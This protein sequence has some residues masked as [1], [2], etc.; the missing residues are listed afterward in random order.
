M[1]PE[2]PEPRPVQSGAGSPDIL[3]WYRSADEPRLPARRARWR[4]ARRERLDA[5]ACLGLSALCFSHAC[6]EI[7]FRADRDFYNRVPVRA[8]TLLALVLNIVAVGALGFAGVQ[9]IR[10]AHRLVWRRLGAIAISAGLLVTLNFVRITYAPLAQ[11]ADWLRT[12]GLLAIVVMALGAALAWPGPALYVM[13]RVALVASPVT[14]VILWVVPWMFL[15]AAVGPVWRPTEPKPL[16]RTPPS[17]RR[18][19]WIVFGELDQRITFEARPAGLDLP[20]LDRLRREAL[21]AV[22]ARPPAAATEVTMPALITGRPVV[23]VAPL[24]PNDLELT[25]TDGKTAPWSAH[26]NVFTRTRTQGYDTALIGWGLPYPRVLGGSLGAADWRPSAFHEASRGATFAEAMWNQWAS[27][28]PPANIPRL[29]ARRFEELAALALRAAT[30]GRFGL[31]LLHLPVPGP[32]AIYDR[33]TE[34]LAPWS[35]LRAGEGYLDNL[36]LADRMLGQ[37]RRGL[38]QARLDDL[39]WLV[40]TSDRPWQASKHYDGRED[41]RVPFLVRPPHGG[42]GTHVDAALNTLVTH[43]LALAILR[44]SIPDARDAATW[45]ER[46]R[47]AAPR[48]YTRLGRPVY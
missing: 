35:F 24:G 17:L 22:N 9:A 48:D 40:V 29:S 47:V 13:R 41:P 38:E 11:W 25:F 5:L 20:E 12:S 15:E 42:H 26:S 18:V 37:L 8:S 1:T 43:D 23:A 7:L 36:A 6:L 19:V 33:A 28:A 16:D 3:S 10:R 32:P 4:L 14:V 45:L 27:L 44:G 21:Y 2:P 39:T 31:V 30:N 46:Q 34:R